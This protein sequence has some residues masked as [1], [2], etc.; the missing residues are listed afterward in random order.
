MLLL[1]WRFD[2]LQMLQKCAEC[3]LIRGLHLNWFKAHL[4][5]FYDFHLDWL[6]NDR[7]EGEVFCLPPLELVDS[8]IYAVLL[9]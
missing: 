4:Y 3:F 6:K 8:S 1:R 2:H 7:K 5:S 9:F